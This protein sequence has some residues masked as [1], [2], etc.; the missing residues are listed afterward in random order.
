MP[1]SRV[2]LANGETG[3]VED[4]DV[5]SVVQS[6][7][8]L[9]QSDYDPEAHEWDPLKHAVVGAAKS[10]SWDLAPGL[11]K[12]GSELVG[13]PEW[14]ERAVQEF[15]EAAATPEGKMGEFVGMF[16]AP[17]LG[18]GRLLGK[19]AAKV[20]EKVGGGAL[21]KAAAGMAGH[22]A[23]GAEVGALASGG[24]V[25]NEALI[26]DKEL[27]SHEVL[28][29]LADEVSHG[30]IMGL[31]IGGGL[32][33]L[34]EGVKFASRKAGE[35][36]SKALEG[37][38]AW[39]KGGSVQTP[40]EVAAE[41]IQPTRRQDTLISAEHDPVD[42]AM[43]RKMDGSP[44]DVKPGPG[45]YRRWNK[46][47]NA[48]QK[49]DQFSRDIASAT[50]DKF[51]DEQKGKYLEGMFFGGHADKDLVKRMS[52][53]WPPANWSD[54]LKA[55]ILAY[56]E[57][58]RIKKAA[59][60]KAEK[61]AAANLKKAQAQH[62]DMHGKSG[63]ELAE[64]QAQ[65]TVP[66]GGAAAAAQHAEKEA[67][68]Q[69]GTIAPGGKLAAEQVD[70]LFV[71]QEAPAIVERADTRIPEYPRIDTATGEAMTVASP[72]WEGPTAP[73]GIAAAA[74]MTPAVEG[75]RGGDS[76]AERFASDKPLVEK[77]AGPITLPPNNEVSPLAPLPRE[78]PAA[79]KAITLVPQGEAQSV[80]K[81]LPGVDV[82]INAGAN[83]A[84]QV[85]DEAAQ[86]ALDKATGKTL[87]STPFENYG[88][89]PL[90]NVERRLAGGERSALAGNIGDR[91]A[92]EFRYDPAFGI[93]KYAYELAAG[94]LRPTRG[95]LQRWEREVTQAHG[96][97]GG[98]D[99]I[100]EAMFRYRILRPGDG[101]AANFQRADE[102]FARAET[103]A[104]TISSNLD[105]IRDKSSAIIETAPVVDRLKELAK[106]LTANGEQI[107]A[108]HVEATADR[109]SQR[110]PHMPIKELRVNELGAKH[111]G[112]RGSSDLHAGM[113]TAEHRANKLMRIEYASVA[114]EAMDKELNTGGKEFLDAQNRDLGALITIQE[115]LDKMVRSGEKP[116][117]DDFKWGA[118]LGGI[119][120]IKGAFGGLGM[121]VA[122]RVMKE[123]GPFAAAALIHSLADKAIV[124]GDALAAALQ[125]SDAAMGDMIRRSDVV[126]HVMQQAAKGFVYGENK[127]D[128]HPHA[129]GQG[130]STREDYKKR[131]EEVRKLAGNPG[132]VVEN[133]AP[134]GHSAVANAAPETSGHMAG[135][136]A[137]VAQYAADRIPKDQ[138][139]GEG[140]MGGTKAFESVKLRPEELRWMR[141]MEVLD[142]PLSAFRKL[143][144]GTLT[145]EQAEAIKD[146]YPA[147]YQ[148]MRRMVMV[149]IQN[150]GQDHRLT[151]QQ[152]QQMNALFGE[153][154][155][156]RQTPEYTKALQEANT[157]L[158][159]ESE[160]GAPGQPPQPG[161]PVFQQNAFS[162]PA[163]TMA[164]P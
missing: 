45:M 8:K 39:F 46:G 18:A 78:V 105:A 85:A 122:N 58:A 151:V 117:I 77:A 84:R 92:G 40:G 21:A 140:P 7:G 123:R 79:E 103:A 71:K 164:Q 110:G 81:T 68:Q 63:E 124:G 12:K 61:D 143:H 15:D 6:G 23:T 96:R 20:V 108:N 17:T 48:E 89:R 26:E 47:L 90:P 118:I 153:A 88:P 128:P 113:E 146:N 154:V 97:P 3:T 43:A 95:V 66:P 119:G 82:G 162:T 70:G 132:A 5:E 36:L 141:T 130:Y 116:G 74:E 98:M 56:G 67:A 125:G 69:A 41:H 147:M 44:V 80:G 62:A 138:I 157:E 22:M 107:V 52:E 115:H 57:N 14:G 34:G 163:D 37:Q 42:L 50:A 159:E 54:S 158:P 136:V 1:R 59:A 28:A 72:K 13:K 9:L 55:D 75:A 134:G 60:K 93:R 127:L 30:G 94:A 11:I 32:G 10:A 133:M 53:E 2:Q 152:Q 145:R 31:A 150:A 131:T 135:A 129:P 104:D 144:D 19:G 35:S 126:K 99:G 49:A 38:R 120:G 148:A 27:L 76:F 65:K 114:R 161:P 102:M 156:P 16:A 73:R 33:A 64:A 29:H 83:A 51:T 87:I 91:K 106:Y 149:E 86:K 137:G 109:L 139:G 25:V 24:R 112:Y 100:G 101:L 155:S 160:G 121:A 142:K 4:S 111:R